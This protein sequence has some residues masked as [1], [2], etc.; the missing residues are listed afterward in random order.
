MQK[1][2][3]YVGY[4][5]FPY[6]CIEKGS[7]IIL[8]GFGKAGRQYYQQIQENKYCN[9]RYAVD[10]TIGR[11]KVFDFVREPGSLQLEENVKVV[12]AIQSADAAAQVVN[13]LHK[14]GYSDSS[15][16]NVHHVTTFPYTITGNTPSGIQKW[17]SAD[18]AR[19][20]YG[21]NFFADWRELAEAFKI[22][23]FQGQ[24]FVRR[25]RDNDG[26]YIMCH[27][28]KSSNAKIAYSF[29]INDDVSWDDDMADEGFDVYM[30]D[31]TID[32]LPH[33]RKRFYYFKKGI[34]QTSEPGEMLDTLENIIRMN[35]HLDK[36]NM[37]LKMDVEGAEY[38]AILNA[39]DT[40]FQ[41]FDQI[42]MEFHNLLNVTG[43][44]TIIPAIEKLSSIFAAVHVHANNYGN[45]VYVEGV[46]YPDTIEITLLNRSKYNLEVCK[47][48]N[49]PI[50]LDM[51]C[52]KMDDDIILGDWNN[53]G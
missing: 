48:V 14:K 38:G 13:F 5:L 23:T 9:V 12:I 26:G 28:Y 8:Y 7:D 47:T 21:E 42:V 53:R 30:Y 6:E 32:R 20:E 46:P 11:K 50:P 45:V 33:E 17:I 37:I 16:V 40:I 29:G 43:Q 18:E 27:P 24:H 4:Y 1:I 22:H 31:H 35:R 25:G 34:S 49:L 10:E 39:D 2:K 36:D 44:E 41:K 19:C 51:P 15:I 3:S 52:R